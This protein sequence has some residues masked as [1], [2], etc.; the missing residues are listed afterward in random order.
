[1]AKTAYIFDLD[2]TL[3]NTDHRLKWIEGEK[4]NWDMFNSE[5]FRDEVFKD[6][7]KILDLVYMAG[8]DIIFVT[9]RD[10]SHRELTV[11]W[12]LSN[13]NLEPEE[14]QLFMRPPGN[15]HADVSV[16]TK[17][18]NENIKGRYE[19]LGVFEDRDR[20]VEMWRNLGLTCF[21]PKKG[22]Y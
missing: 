6:V 5:C 18:Y 22:D 17:I 11:E 9:G 3:C 4:P 16:K 19:I 10:G 14:Y 20:V 13:L 2:G 12:L 8:N 1:M 21:Q 15:R 7:A